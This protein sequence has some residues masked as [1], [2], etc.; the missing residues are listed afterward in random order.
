M[1][2]LCWLDWLLSFCRLLLTLNGLLWDSRFLWTFPLELRFLLC[3]ILISGQQMLWL[4][5]LSSWYCCVV[6]NENNLG[7]NARLVLY[8]FDWHCQMWEIDEAVC[9]IN[10]H[11]LMS[12]KVQTY[13][14]SC[15]VLHYDK[16]FCNDLT[17]NVKFKCG[18]CYWLFQLAMCY[19][20]LK[21]RSFID[22]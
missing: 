7:F 6:V 20:N 11:T 14:K 17:S 5:L 13:N 1:I 15:Q 8:L 9:S 12:H 10:D 19:L 18:C 3:S 22:F 21:V 4:L 2:P 16:V